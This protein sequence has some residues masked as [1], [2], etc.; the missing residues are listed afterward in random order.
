MSA[1]RLDQL[2]DDRQRGSTLPQAFYTDPEVFA[3]DIDRVYSRNWL[4]AGHSC[5]LR[6]SGD[7]VTFD[8][9]PIALIIT[10]DDDGVLHA[11][12][13][14]CRHR[15]SRILSK[16]CGHA[17]K[18]VCP[19]HRWSYAS[20]GSLTQAK[21]MGD[22]FRKDAYGLV[23]SH[24]REIAGLIF[25]CV[26]EDPPDFDLAHAAIAPQLAPHG[27]ER[28]KVCAVEDYEIKANWKVVFE[29]NRE[30]Y[31]CPSGHPEYTRI[32]FDIGMPGDQRVGSDY[33]GILASRRARW[34]AN[35]LAHTEQ[36]N[37]PNGSW[38]RCARMPLREGFVTESLDGR[39]V[40]PL[41]GDLTDPDAG[42]LR[43]IAFPNAW[44]H[45]NSDYFNSTQLIPVGPNRT[46]ARIV[47]LVHEDAR[48]GVDYDPARVTEFWKVTTEQDWR[49]CENN[50]AGIES[51]DY[52]P[53]PLSPV[54][55]SGVETLATWYLDQLRSPAVTRR[56]HACSSA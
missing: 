2:L 56:S 18:L 17:G 27:L 29:N 49:L 45:A 46:R 40:A 9:G 4:F 7:Y 14:T 43:I 19:Y 48:E 32:N 21:W 42:S 50:Q 8:T 20:D 51:R 44:F 16:T 41:M 39:P 13:N 25:V 37:F 55:E 31:H 38:F 54:T 3:A 47:Y 5:Q 22:G 52:R 28:A 10:R 30:C 23:R 24:V 36:V 6:R 15:G 1:S 26:A 35:G 34:H 11:L 12:A 53:G 33:E